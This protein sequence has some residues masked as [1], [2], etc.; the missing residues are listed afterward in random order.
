VRI[1]P[2]LNAYFIF[3]IHE[4]YVSLTAY[5]RLINDKS[6]YLVFL[7]YQA[8][9]LIYKRNINILQ[10]SSY[11]RKI[12]HY[13]LLAPLTSAARPTLDNIIPY[14]WPKRFSLH[15]HEKFN[16]VLSLECPYR[17]LRCTFFIR[18]NRFLSYA[19]RPDR[20]WGPHIQLIPG[21][22]PRG[23]LAEARS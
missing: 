15:D 9:L 7:K 3:R 13:I 2:I 11:P 23:K 17:A 1:C 19:K 10:V 6:L 8:P 20:F 18:C 14:Q 12:P 16:R 21:I 5:L 22:L 4:F